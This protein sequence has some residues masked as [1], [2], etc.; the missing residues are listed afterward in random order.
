VTA[1]DTVRSD[2]S[3]ASEVSH[4]AAA[5]ITE[6]FE[7]AARQARRAALLG[8]LALVIGVLGVTWLR[9]SASAPR[10]P[11]WIAVAVWLAAIQQCARMVMRVLDARNDADSLVRQPLRAW[12]RPVIVARRRAKVARWL[13]LY[14]TGEK[15]PPA[16]FAAVSAVGEWPVAAPALL[17]DVAGLPKKGRLLTVFD[18]A[19]GNLIGF[20]RVP[21]TAKTVALMR[22]GQAG[23]QAAKTRQ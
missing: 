9:S 15:A 18:A 21:S 2:G 5:A 19:T 13:L 8:L 1:S 22:D 14:A 16:P 11:L 10:L 3:A 7:E 12:T 17:V 20:G 4:Q 6:H 23:R